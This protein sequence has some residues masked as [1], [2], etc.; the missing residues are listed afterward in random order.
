MNPY[1]SKTP[2]TS[3]SQTSPSCFFIFFLFL[4]YFL[5]LTLCLGAGS[6]ANNNPLKTKIDDST[7]L[8]F[9]QALLLLYS[10]ASKRNSL[11]KFLM[12]YHVFFSIIFPFISLCFLF[13]ICR[14]YFFLKFFY[15]LSK[16][17]VS[18]QNPIIIFTNY[19]QLQL[20]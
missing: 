12:C 20:F 1:P 13:N 18:S 5:F 4:S 14:C 7:F 15:D 2:N 6:C 17:L 11:P 3:L 10:S 8:L 19:C 9:Q 16:P